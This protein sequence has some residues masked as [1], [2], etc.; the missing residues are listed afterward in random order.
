MNTYEFTFL[1]PETAATTKLE[2]ALESLKG[3]KLDEKAW[4][5]RL[6]AYPIDKKTDAYYFTWYIQIDSASIA[7]FKKKLQYDK[8]VIRYLLI[9]KD[10]TQKVQKKTKIKKEDTKKE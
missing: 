1:V 8:L 9:E 5:K 3:K 7:Q 6:F 2:K 4:G 10:Y